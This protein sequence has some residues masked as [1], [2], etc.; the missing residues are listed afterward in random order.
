[1]QGLRI[2][3]HN[4]EIIDDEVSEEVTLADELVF[5]EKSW[6]LQMFTK[7]GMVDKKGS[8][9]LIHPHFQTTPLRMM[10]RSKK[11]RLGSGGIPCVSCE[12]I[13]KSDKTMEQH[14]KKYH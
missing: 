12:K 2:I 14:R 7:K 13:F 5:L 9:N 8:R 10:T 4:F 1:M 3:I 11:A 6:Y